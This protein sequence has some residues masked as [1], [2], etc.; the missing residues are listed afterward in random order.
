[1]S[2]PRVRTIQIRIRR[3]YVFDFAQISTLEGRCGMWAV[4]IL[5]SLGQFSGFGLFL[6][7]SAH[8]AGIRGSV[9]WGQWRRAVVQTCETSGQDWIILSGTGGRLIIQIIFLPWFSFSSTRNSFLSVE[10]LDHFSTF[11]FLLLPICLTLFH[12]SPIPPS[13]LA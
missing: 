11:C 13:F 5:A 9:L 12:H 7:H 4:L 2:G 3:R 10:S 8:G 1:M 6:L